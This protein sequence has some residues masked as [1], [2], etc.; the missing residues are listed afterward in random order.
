MDEFLFYRWDYLKRFDK[1]D[2]SMVERGVLGFD[3]GFK[4]KPKIQRNRLVL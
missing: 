3:L 2:I 1:L 4:T